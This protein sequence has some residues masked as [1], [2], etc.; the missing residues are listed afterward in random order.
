MYGRKTGFGWKIITVLAAL[1]LLTALFATLAERTTSSENAYADSLRYSAANEVSVL[2]S[3]GSSLSDSKSGYKYAY[4]SAGN[5]KDNTDHGSDSYAYLPINRSG[6]STATGELSSTTR[7][8]GKALIPGSGSYASMIMSAEDDSTMYLNANP[9]VEFAFTFG[10][11]NEFRKILKDRMLS[12]T[13]QPYVLCSEPSAA[14]RV[15]LSSDL[16]QPAK[17]KITLSY[18][19][20]ANNVNTVFCPPEKL[21]DL[22]CTDTLVLGKKSQRIASASLS[23]NAFF[24]LNLSDWATNGAFN[25]CIREVGIKVEVTPDSGIDIKWDEETNGPSSSPAMI[26]EVTTCLVQGVDRHK[27]ARSNTAKENDILDINLVLQT[28]YGTLTLDTASYASYAQ[29]D[30]LSLANSKDGTMFRRLFLKENEDRFIISW[31]VTGGDADP[32][33]SA[34]NM[35]GQAISWIVKAGES[36]RA[37][38]DGE[39]LTL[40]PSI[41]YRNASGTLSELGGSSGNMKIEILVDAYAPNSPEFD[42]ENKFYATYLDDDKRIYY[43]T[44]TND[45]AKKELEGDTVL[46]FAITGEDNNSRPTLSEATVDLLNGTD[47]IIYYQTDYFG[48]DNPVSLA[49]RNSQP[50]TGPLYYQMKDGEGNYNGRYDIYMGSAPDREETYY[51]L[52]QDDKLV[53]GDSIDNT[54]DTYFKRT[55]YGYFIKNT[56]TTARDNTVYYKSTVYDWKNNGLQ[57]GVY[58]YVKGGKVEYGEYD[59]YVNMVAAENTVRKY[60]VW[61]IQLIAYDVVGQKSMSLRKYFIDIDISE[62]DFPLYLESPDEEVSLDNVTVTLKTVSQSGKTESATLVRGELDE[63]DVFKLRRSDKVLVEIKF[64]DTATYNGFKFTELKVGN[65]NIVT[66]DYKYSARATSLTYYSFENTGGKTSYYTFEVDAS[67]CA[68]AENRDMYFYF[69]NIVKIDVANAKNNVV[70]INYDGT[71]QEIVTGVA[72]LQRLGIRPEIATVYYVDPDRTVRVSTGSSNIPVNAGTYYFASEIVNH[73]LY[74]GQATGSLVISPRQPSL[75]TLNDGLR[76][77]YGDSVAKLDSTLKVKSVKVTNPATGTEIEVEAYIPTSGI[78]NIITYNRREYFLSTMSS[79]MVPGYYEFEIADKTSKDYV[80]PGAGALSLIVTFTP[81][82]GSIS[83]T[84]SGP[85]AIY[86]YAVDNTRDSETYGKWTVVRD[87]NYQVVTKTITLTVVP[88]DHVNFALER[89]QENGNGEIDTTVI[90]STLETE[91]IEYV[92][93]TYNAQA[94]TVAFTITAVD[95]GEVVDLKDYTLIYYAPTSGIELTRKEL[96]S[97]SY[98]Q[99]VPKTAGRYAMRIRLNEDRKGCNYSGTFYTYI[100]INKINLTVNP[101]QT[102]LVNDYEYEQLPSVTLKVGVEDFAGSV[103]GFQ[104]LFY[105]NVTNDMQADCVEENLIA[106][107]NKRIYLE[108]P[109]K[110]GQYWVTI[111]IDD[112]NY[113]GYVTARYTVSKVDNANTHFAATWPSVNASIVNSEYNLMAGQPVSEV[114]LGSTSSFKYSVRR[115]RSK[116]SSSYSSV[117]VDGMLFKVPYTY[118]KWLT[119][120]SKADTTENRRLYL[121][122]APEE[123]ASY[124]LELQSWYICFV[125]GSRDTDGTILFNENYDFIYADIK[126][127]VGKAIVDWTEAEIEPIDYCAT[128]DWNT[129]TINREDENTK[130][131]LNIAEKIGYLYSTSNDNH[132]LSEDTYYV[133]D[134]KYVYKY[135]SGELYDYLLD[136]NEPTIRSAGDAYINVK[137]RFAE[138]NNDFDTEYVGN[139]VLTVEKKGL[140]VTIED[141]Q[142]VYN[143]Y[144]EEGFYEEGAIG[145]EGFVQS[146]LDEQLVIPANLKGTFTYKDATSDTMYNVSELRAGSYIATFTLNHANY[147]GS[148]SFPLTIVRADIRKT[149]DPL[150]DETSIVYAAGIRA[151]VTFSGGT[152]LAEGGETVYG[153]VSIKGEYRLFDKTTNTF[154]VIKNLDAETVFPEA[155]TIM[156]L[157]YVVTPTNTRDYNLLVGTDENGGYLDVTVGKADVSAEMSVSPKQN[158]YIYKDIVRMESGIRNLLRYEVKN[159]LPFRVE[160]YDYRREQVGMDGNYLNAGLYTVRITIEDDN[161]QGIA[162]CVLTVDKKNAYVSLTENA[163]TIVTDGTGVKGVR[164]KYTGGSKVIDTVV[165]EKNGDAYVQIRESVSVIYVMD[166]VALASAPSEIGKYD[167]EL[168]LL[169]ANYK[170]ADPET[171]EELQK[172]ASFLIIAVDD[173]EI[174]LYNLD[175]LYTVQKNVFAF[176]GS[177]AVSDEDFVIL[178]EKDGTWYENLPIEA[179]SYSVYLEFLPYRLNGYDERLNAAEFRSKNGDKRNYKLTINRYPKDIMVANEISVSYTGERGEK[180]SPTTSPYGI[181]LTYEYKLSDTLEWTSSTLSDLGALDAGRYDVRITV[182]DKNYRGEKI[183]KYTVTQAKLTLKAYPTFGAYQYNSETEPEYLGGGSYVFGSRNV[184]GTFG[185]SVSGIGSLPVGEHNA[186]FTFTPD[187]KNFT[188]ASGTVKVRIVKRELDPSFITFADGLLETEDYTVEYDETSRALSTIRNYD[189]IYRYPQENADVSVNVAYYKDGVSQLPIEIG[190]YT[191]RATVSGKN[192]TL[193]KEWPYEFVI[194]QG[195]PVIQENPYT[196]KTFKLNDTVLLADIYGGKAVVASTGN[197]IPGRFEMNATLL[198]TANDFPIDVTFYPGDDSFKSVRFTMQVNVVGKDPFTLNGE[199]K[200]LGSTVKG[201]NWTNKVLAPT[202]V[203]TLPVATGNR[204][205]SGDAHGAVIVIVPRSGAESLEYGATIGDFRLEFRAAHEGCAEC[206]AKV[207]QLRNNGSLLFKKEAS[208]VPQVGSSLEVTYSLTVDTVENA[209]QY[210]NLNGFI[211]LG[212]ALTKKKLTSANAQFEWILFDGMND[213]ILNVYRNGERLIGVDYRNGTKNL[214]GAVAYTDQPENVTLNLSVDGDEGTVSL[215]TNDYVAT[216]VRTEIKRFTRLA[217]SAISVNRIEKFFDFIPIGVTDLQVSVAGTAYPVTED[218]LSLAIEKDGEVSEGLHKGTYS[219]TVYI[220]DDLN[221]VYGSKTVSFTIKNRNVSAELTL[222]KNR[223]TSNGKTVFYDSFNS[224]SHTMLTPKLEGEYDISDSEYSVLIKKISEPE[225]E[226]KRPTALGAGTYDV[227]VVVYGEDYSGEAYFTYVVDPQRINMRTSMT[228]Y[229]VTYGT[230]E[231]SSFGLDVSFTDESGDAFEFGDRGGYTVSYYADNYAKTTVRPTNAGLYSII[232]E[233][234]NKNYSI[235]GNIVGYEI[236]PKTTRMEVAPTLVS[237]DVEGNHLVYGQKLGYLQLNTTSAVVKDTSGN[238]IAGKYGVSKEDAAR[239]LFAGEREIRI[240][241]TPNDSNYESITYTERISVARKVIKLEF[242]NLSAS[243]NGS[244]RRNELKYKE[245]SEPVTILFTFANATGQIVDPVSAGVYTVTVS[246]SDNNYVADVSSA[247]NGSGL[248]FTITRAEVN[249]SITQIPSAG[250]IGVGESLMKSVLSGGSVYYKGFGTP[251][252]G[253]YSYVEDGRT[254]KN[255]GTYAVKFLFVPDD[256]N[257]FA[258]YIDEVEI[259]I[260]KGSA[261]LTPGENVVTYGEKLNVQNLAFT[262]LPAGL[263]ASVRVD[264]TCDGVTYADGDALPAGTYWF[265][266]WVDG[267]DYA[268]EAIKFSFVVNKK[269]IDVDFVSEDEVVTSY[270]V[271]YGESVKI[272]VRMYDENTD[273][274]R[275]YYLRDAA[276]MKSNI[277]Y[278]FVS[279]AGTDAYESTTAPTQIGTYDLTVIVIHDNYVA[280]RTVIYRV[281]T[282]VVTDIS[283]D[284]DSLVGQVYGTVVSP[285]VNTVPSNVNY[286]IV[287]QGYDKTVPTMVGTY[288]ITVYIDDGN[289]ASKQVSAVFRINPKPVSVTNIRVQDKAYDGVDSVGISASLSGIMYNDEVSLSIKATTHDGETAVGEYYVDITECKLTGLNASNYTLE[290]PKFDGKVRIYA[291]RVNATNGNSYILSNNGFKDGTTV[292]FDEV[293]TERNK[294]SVWS[295]MLGVEST[296]MQYAIKVNNVAEINADQYKVCV[297]IPDQYKGKEFKLEFAGE[298]QNVTNGYVVEGD[299][300]SFYSSTTAGQVVFSTAEFKYGYV[301]TAAI[302]LIV[303]ITIIVLLILNPLSSRRS[304]SDPAAAKRAIRKIK[305]G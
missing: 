156:R 218:A 177:N 304:V 208:F 121:A 90:P 151:S 153:A 220:R 285:I 299:Y 73:D 296:V 184:P 251:I 213:Y 286:Y 268:S 145:Y 106:D 100:V 162:E 272:D 284:L 216:S 21:K 61:E 253:T 169:S 264:L 7:C 33:P 141:T 87:V 303:L 125:A 119:D 226:Y 187:E 191:V 32:S 94:R 71:G 85:E 68:Y 166:N 148:T 49:E 297:E 4:V 92:I 155:G 37:D 232:V 72:E 237:I 57:N 209:S 173:T 248:R 202:F 101:D 36:T 5:L 256:N 14:T 66:T 24:Q 129:V 111:T 262:T 29:I 230:N 132:G 168:K 16:T 113:E 269:E 161:Y 102:S 298:L 86:Q 40:K 13:V 108:T 147:S 54:K 176:M 305:K 19:D 196:V 75:A 127:S 140:I 42:E 131:R 225:T 246:V 223:R 80:K 231:W 243:Y 76:I 159:D 274:R 137:A 163:S 95:D 288:N 146:D 69:K 217:E 48:E 116:T 53:P 64:N 204:N 170:L 222:V 250:S 221:K 180:F 82:K 189:L 50:F 279:R 78:T 9:G 233:P 59:I 255:T 67:Y 51:V 60:G 124:S 224:G 199:Q 17:A 214:S 22:P 291:A 242:E 240:T 126:V 289:Y 2:G 258:A 47:T 81:V 294:T 142:A 265:T 44:V 23:G 257:N 205:T 62:Y 241:F 12:V 238:V 10:L 239:I 99:D 114:N 133:V 152:F 18:Y 254:F 97:L 198:T 149:A 280:T 273:G 211:D 201:E 229:S 172:L 135:V 52:K 164:K 118:K 120:E 27:D 110:A 89:R 109:V 270:T 58:A 228:R 157:F 185:I 105:N 192:Y 197:E 79:D 26:D 244:S 43:T 302:L 39:Y 91:E 266:A 167:A 8:V 55:N 261:T 15:Q 154:G 143:L 115:V 292:T 190:R 65:F 219:V 174:E 98:T 300:V 252:K 186:T 212:D 276:T 179:G 283:F 122:T 38:D 30:D 182:A 138:D 112:P 150:V 88:D 295:K 200:D 183:I 134:S 139:K 275:T 203:S 301:V 215:E 41:S 259:T 56:D 188:D 175:Q 194:T 31:K 96:E 63:P 144:R 128:I 6:G 267:V 83:Y 236:V 210:N 11:S 207:S 234:V 46:R 84:A 28:D 282:G 1:M 25:I 247:I 235:Y 245:I 171:D 193:T 130:L 293:A 206:N 107:D 3:T 103:A 181:A 281:V 104:F 20:S 160:L 227:K 70:N 178:F 77:N 165:R 34:S 195:T 290:K 93:Y 45:D 158:S 271:T 35:S 278:V 277:E 136:T 263:N 117:N 287:Y 260:G 74:Y 123:P 249:K